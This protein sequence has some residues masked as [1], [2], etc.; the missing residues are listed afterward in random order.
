MRPALTR[1]GGTAGYTI[2]ELMITVTVIA[3]LAAIAIP[4]LDTQGYRVNGAVRGLTASLGYAQRLAVSLQHDVRVA[5]DSAGGR[6]RIHEDRNN[7]GNMDPGERVTSTPLDEGVVFARGAAPPVSFTTGGS[8][9]T[10][11]SFTRTQGVLPCVIFR[12]DGS[13]SENGGFYITT[14]RG[15][16]AGN[17]TLVRAGEMIRSTGR[18]IWHSYATGTWVQG[19]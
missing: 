1:P 15:L 19:N 8:G 16:A 18:V 14:T 10:T 11:F 5:F 17:A 12:R 2:V 3:L 6:I 9:M 4:R 7:D 13:A